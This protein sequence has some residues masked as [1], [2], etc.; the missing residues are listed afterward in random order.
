MS[1]LLFYDL[2]LYELHE[3]S[4]HGDKTTDIFEIEIKGWLNL[5]EFQCISSI[6]IFLEGSTRGPPHE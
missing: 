6:F 1:S 5:H 4:E 2:T 3:L